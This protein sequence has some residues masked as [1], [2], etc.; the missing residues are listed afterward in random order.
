MS[1]PV[2]QNEPSE[3]CKATKEELLNKKKNPLDID[4]DCPICEKR[5]VLC[6]VANHPHREQQAGKF[7]Y[8][9]I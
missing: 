3:G 5:G 8:D 1:N 6:E 2:R 4:D 7:Y 9:A